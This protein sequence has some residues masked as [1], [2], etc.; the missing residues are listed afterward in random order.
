MALRTIFSR[1]CEEETSLPSSSV[2]R[3]IRRAD[4][5]RVDYQLNVLSAWN[6]S[7]AIRT[8]RGVQLLRYDSGTTH[9]EGELFEGFGEARERLVTRA[10]LCNQRER[11]RRAPDFSGCNL[12]AGSLGDIILEVGSGSGGH[13]PASAGASSTALLPERTRRISAKGR[14][15]QHHRMCRGSNS[16]EKGRG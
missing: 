2:S 8:G 3:V 1:E 5:L 13:A 9:L 12:H 10:S 14:P 11:R 7:M 4:R 6:L 16:E 15:R